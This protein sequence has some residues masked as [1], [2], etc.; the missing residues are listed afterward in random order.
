MNIFNT[1]GLFDNIKSYI[2]TRVEMAKL[3][4]QEQIMAFVQRILVVLGLGLIASLVML[5][6]LFGLAAYLNQILA[7]KFWGYWIIALFFLVIFVGFGLW[8]G[9]FSKKKSD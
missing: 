4:V 2:D 5:F 3:G 6:F 7:S 9:L 1:G 8:S